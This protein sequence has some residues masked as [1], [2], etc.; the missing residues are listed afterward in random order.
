M[1]VVFAA[2]DISLVRQYSICGT[3]HCSDQ[4]LQCRPALCRYCVKLKFLKQF[5]E[6][7]Y[8]CI[9]FFCSLVRHAVCF[10]H[11]SE[12]LCTAFKFRLFLFQNRVESVLYQ[13]QINRHHM[14][15]ELFHKLTLVADNRGKRSRSETYLPDSHAEKIPHRTADSR[16]AFYSFFK[17]LIVHMSIYYVTERH[18]HSH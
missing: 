4:K 9:L 13:R 16:K 15:V 17:S 14:N 5:L 6:Q 1:N 7:N 18:I 10:V 2:Y 3:W 8:I 11:T 12:P